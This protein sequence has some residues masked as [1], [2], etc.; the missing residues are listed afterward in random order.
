MFPPAF[1][2]R[3]MQ[4]ICDAGEKNFLKIRTNDISRF[5]PSVIG[6]DQ[7]WVEAWISLDDIELLASLVAAL[8]MRLKYMIDQANMDIQK[9]SVP[10]LNVPSVGE[11]KQ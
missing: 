6:G 2:S 10:K 1:Y 7:G 4:V 9:I 8:S 3:Q 5:K 11:A